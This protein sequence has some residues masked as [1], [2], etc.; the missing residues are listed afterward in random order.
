[1]KLNSSPILSNY[2]G[3]IYSFG[4]ST[5]TY[6]PRSLLNSPTYLNKTAN[7]ANKSI[8]FESNL[9]GEYS[10][11]TS[12]LPNK[13]ILEEKMTNSEFRASNSVN[14]VANSV[15]CLIILIFPSLIGVNQSVNSNQPPFNETDVLWLGQLRK[16]LVLRSLQFFNSF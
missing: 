10:T 6:K 3:E 13:P 5:K 4:T 15:L 14:L 1:M 7:R 9:S 2:C 8:E 12:P 11:T 16:L